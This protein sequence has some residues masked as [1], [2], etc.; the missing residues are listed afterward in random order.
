MKKIWL[1]VVLLGIS[2]GLAHADHSGLDVT[3]A[4]SQLATF[5]ETFRVSIINKDGAKLDSMFLPGTPFV[6]VFDDET[7][8]SI[9]AKRPGASKVVVT[10]SKKF[11]S[12]VTVS[13]KPLE[14]KFDAIGIDTDGTLA[15]VHFAYG[16][17]NDGELI[18]DGMETWQL[19]NSET[20]WKISAMLFSVRLASAPSH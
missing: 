18:N 12:F 4:R 16:F 9:K 15:S 11:T 13:A 6:S 17:Y 14:E 3:V 7:F 19:V 20:G 2:I 10:D 8:R 1:G 5:V